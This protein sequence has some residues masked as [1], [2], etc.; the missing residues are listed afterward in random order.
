MLDSSGYYFGNMGLTVYKD[1]SAA[2]LEK[3]EPISWETHTYIPGDTPL[4]NGPF[5]EQWIA[6]AIA[7]VYLLV[8]S[9]FGRGSGSMIK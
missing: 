4:N 1:I 5:I 9:D 6:V 7:I 3:E 8:T 2:G